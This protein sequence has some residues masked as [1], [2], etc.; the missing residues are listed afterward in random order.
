MNAF[1]QHSVGVAMASETIAKAVNH[2]IPSDLF[3]AGLIHDMGKIALYVIDDNSLVELVDFAKA[4]E[5]SY[6]EAEMELGYPPHTAIGSLL[7]KK[8]RLPL[9]MKACIEFHHEKNPN[10]RRDLTPELNQAVDIVYFANLLTHALKFGDS[11][12][13]KVIGVPKDVMERLGIDPDQGFKSVA[14]D[15]KASLSK[16]EDFIRAINGE[17]A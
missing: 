17:D 7:S 16:A 1:W 15:V 14:R 5:M 8:W 2:P 12:H 6:V 13:D 4:K 9:A 10:L 3:T 11:G